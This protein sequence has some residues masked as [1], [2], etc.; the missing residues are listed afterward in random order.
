M[1]EY[2]LECAFLVPIRRDS[3]FSDG[4][5]HSTAAWDWLES[6]LWVRYRGRTRPLELYDGVYAD[7]SGNAVQDLSRKYFIALREEQI[8]DLRELLRE[9]KGV[10]YQECFYL[11]VRGHVEFV[12]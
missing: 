8:D 10:F 5:L 3:R 9:A 11:S 12:D 6:E 7:K 4:E 2:F 1:S